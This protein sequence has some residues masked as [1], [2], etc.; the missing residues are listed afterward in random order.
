[1][2]LSLVFD[3]T[4]MVIRHVYFRG[5][6]ARRNRRAFS[7]IELVIAIVLILVL[8]ALFV[9]ALH[10]ARTM[11]QRE[12]CAANLSRI[13][14]MLHIYLDD[15]DG[16]FPTVLDQPAW[17]YGGLRYSSGEGMPY[18]DSSRPLNQVLLLYS[19]QGPEA[20]IYCCP[21]DAGIAGQIP[22]LGTGG[23]SACQS[24]GTSYRANACLFDSRIAGVD[25]KPRG[26]FR[27]EIITAPSRMLV[28]GDAI[29]YEVAESTGRDADWHNAGGAGNIL[30]LDN[31]VRLQQVRPRGIGGPVVFD[32][33]PS[34]G[35]G[36]QSPPVEDE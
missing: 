16:Q 34:G 4:A 15:H 33:S 17:H 36:I 2:K 13:G 14:E 8:L 29:W 26:L 11:S 30:F 22:E 25:D 19:L 27:S 12:Q 18:L 20:M 32:P 21:A 23:R 6:P 24:F 1:M 5:M 28:L 3:E 10:S 7:L 31:S 35:R 9:P